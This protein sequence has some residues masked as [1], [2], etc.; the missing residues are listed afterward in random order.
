MLLI[1]LSSVKQYTTILLIGLAVFVLVSALFLFLFIK[2]KVYS[3]F[4]KLVLLLH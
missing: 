4:V 2:L 3:I 1:A